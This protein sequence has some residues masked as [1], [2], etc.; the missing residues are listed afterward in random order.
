MFLTHLSA[1]ARAEESV[2][3][4]SRVMISATLSA[5]ASRMPAA[6]RIHSARSEKLVSL[7][8]GALI[9]SSIVV[10]TIVKF[11]GAA[12]LV[13]LGI[14]AIRHRKNRTAAADAPPRGRWRTL[15]EGV[16]V[17]ISNPKTIVF[18][19]AILPQFVSV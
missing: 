9:E 7:G 18:F 10:F 15:A 3:P 19:L 5:S 14:Q 16:V 4:I 11:A 2:L 13:Y 8:L 17:G 1:S 6:A 12:F